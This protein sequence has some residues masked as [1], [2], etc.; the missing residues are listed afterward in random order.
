MFNVGYNSVENSEKCYNTF[1]EFFCG[2]VNEFEIDIKTVAD[3][4]VYFSEGNFYGKDWTDNDIYI[5]YKGSE[6]K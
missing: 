1:T 4:V 3:I 6:T 2:L 5:V